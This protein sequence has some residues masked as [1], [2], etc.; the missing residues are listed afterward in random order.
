MP[1]SASKI[2]LSSAE[3]FRHWGSS[4]LP[5][6]AILHLVCAKSFRTP[7]VPGYITPILILTVIC[8]GVK[9]KHSV[10]FW[11]DLPLFLSL[12]LPFS[13][14]SSQVSYSHCLRNTEQIWGG[15]ESESLDDKGWLDVFGSLR[16]LKYTDD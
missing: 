6:V 13:P 16:W 11:Q 7:H 8:A 12:L 3:H 4:W 14:D 1:L 5:L 15:G 10:C 9:T 2:F